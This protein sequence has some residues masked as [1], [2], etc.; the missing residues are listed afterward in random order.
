MQ[1]FAGSDFCHTT[2][3]FKQLNKQNRQTNFKNRLMAKFMCV[4]TLSGPISLRNLFPNLTGH[5]I[6]LRVST[7]GKIY[8]GRNQMRKYMKLI[9]LWSCS[10]LV[11]QWLFLFL[12]RDSVHQW[13]IKKQQ[14][15]NQTCD[16]QEVSTHS[17]FGHAESIICHSC[18]TVCKAFYT[19]IWSPRN[20]VHPREVS[21]DG[22]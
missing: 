22:G 9:L 1:H 2:S 16:Y 7:K 20:L 11:E 18:M 10:S 6:N 14:I 21:F 3:Y 4:Y 19:F 5:Y 13:I 12:K 17:N 8:I 15:I